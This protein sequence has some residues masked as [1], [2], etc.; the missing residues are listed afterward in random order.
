M[1]NHQTEILIGIN[2]RNLFNPC[3]QIEMYMYIIQSLLNLAGSSGVGR[4]I[5]ML[6]MF[7]DAVLTVSC[8]FAYRWMK[9]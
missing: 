5:S 1:N 6:V 3:A 4:V 9:Q 7:A 2:L 8:F